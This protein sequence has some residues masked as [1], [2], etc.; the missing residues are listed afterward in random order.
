LTA[1][2]DFQTFTVPTALNQIQ[3]WISFLTVFKVHTTI[4]TIEIGCTVKSQY[5]NARYPENLDILTDLSSDI[6]FRPPSLILE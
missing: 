6:K 2:L 4:C 5:L 1:W 3:N